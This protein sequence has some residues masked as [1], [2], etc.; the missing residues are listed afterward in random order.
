MFQN[1]KQL[2]SMLWKYDK[3]YYLV[4]F[5]TILLQVT[6]NLVNVVLPRYLI[7]YLTQ[8]E[9]TRAAIVAGMLCLAGVVIGVGSIVL[10]YRKNL[11]QQGFHFRLTEKLAECS[12][13]VPYEKFEDFKVRE[14]YQFAVKC[15]D[16]GSAGKILDY[17][18]NA[19]SLL[20][21]LASLLYLTSYVVWWLWM[22]II[23]SII[24]NTVCESYRMKYHYE[25]TRSQNAVDMRMLYARDRLTWKAFA[26]EVRLFHMYDYVVKT[27]E[28][29]IDALS[30]IQKERAT[31]TF[32]ALFWSYLVNGLQMIAVY[33]Y[34]GYECYRGSFSIGE[35]TLLT[36]AILSVSQLTA[37][38]ASSYME[39]KQQGEYLKDY[40]SFLS[41]AEAQPGARSV[42]TKA[43]FEITFDQV[44][45]AYPGS[46]SE[47]VKGVSH[48]FQAGKKYGIVG[49][50]GSG[51]TT[52]IHLL[53]G[54]YD[55]T[56]G[57]ILL[58]QSPVQDLDREQY[59][60]LFSPVLQ[61]F[62]LYAYTIRENIEMASEKDDDKTRELMDKM[63]I[64]DRIGQLPGKIDTYITSE[65]ED[66]GT[67][68]SGG[69]Q[70]KIAIM[71]AFYKDAPILVLDEPTSALSPKS[72]YELYGEINGLAA[73]KTV[74]FISHRMASCRMC[75]E[76]LVF[77]Q[78]RI[79]ECG[80]H[81]ALMREQGLYHR[82]FQ[83]QASLYAEENYEENEERLSNDN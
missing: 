53:M 20:L 75:D 15:A 69:E 23:V 43:G 36:L 31:K 81:E 51:K 22:I 49:A 26:K 66:Q 24:V 55:A 70:Q 2:F 80:T 42:R 8:D 46:D 40:F 12:H 3:K 47:A 57:R 21:S 25:G 68:F 71:R 4:F 41:Y 52:F 62:N 64:A 14:E 44:H 33:G 63:N 32:R 74:F 59:Y 39:V 56:S 37:G 73:D 11:I 17:V 1:I 58:D 83:A 65:Y 45:F 6:N 13:S 48:T 78:G 7:D 67:E 30:A 38:I 9:I 5:F 18:L 35:F 54:L 77:D 61:D 16:E 29:Y 79:V 10:Q 72:E 82:M 28:H 34:V 50:N 60:G 19:V 76:I 27:A